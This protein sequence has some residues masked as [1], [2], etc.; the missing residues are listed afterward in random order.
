MATL[1][2]G[3]AGFDAAVHVAQALALLRAVLADVGTFG[4]EMLV[5]GRTQD[6]D[7]RRHPAGLRAGQHELNMTRSGMIAT[8][9][10][11]VPC[12][13]AEACL[14]AA[15]AGIYAGLHVLIDVMHRNV[16]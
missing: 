9:F 16:S 8:L 13:H 2:A 12:D 11:A 10:Q 5:V 1:R 4:T 15:K 6:H 14:V 7:M 3:A